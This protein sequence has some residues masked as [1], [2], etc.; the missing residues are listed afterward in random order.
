MRRTDCIEKLN[1]QFK[2]EKMEAEEPET[3]AKKAENEE[4]GR[5]LR[6]Q[7]KVANSIHTRYQELKA[8]QHQ[9][10]DELV[11]WPTL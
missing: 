6:D 2:R 9:L 7:N 11:C 3:K 1:V 4:Y 5:K 8:V 10:R